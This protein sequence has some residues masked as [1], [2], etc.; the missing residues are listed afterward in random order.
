MGTGQML[1]T[2][3]AIMLLGT[4][5]LSTNKGID[6]NST[7]LL[8][9]NFGLEATS[10]AASVIDEAEYLPFDDATATSFGDATVEYKPINSVNQLTE[11]PLL[12]SEGHG[13]DIRPDDFDDYNGPAP[14][15]GYRIVSDTLSTG[16]YKIKTSVCYVSPNDLEGVSLQ[17]TWFKRL[18]VCVWNTAD[19]LDTV[20]MSSIYSYWYFR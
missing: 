19:S 1:I 18:D 6:N 9:T 15:P 11:R 7:I 8:K 10:L 20:R 3:G 2:V 4:V 13:D 12:G 5:I 17:R 14:G 16:I